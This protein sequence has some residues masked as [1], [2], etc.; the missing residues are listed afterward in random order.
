MRRIL[1]EDPTHDIKVLVD[2]SEET[3]RELQDEMGDK[4]R[5]ALGALGAE[6][7]QRC[8]QKEFPNGD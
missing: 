5:L 8:L 4:T 2:I 3:F 7:I 6:C 1:F